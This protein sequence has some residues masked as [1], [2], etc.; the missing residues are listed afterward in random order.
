MGKIRVKTLG[1]E[2]FEAKQADKDKKRR[3]SKKAAKEK[4][5][6]KG[7]GL[8]GGQQVKVMEGVELKPE[9]EALLKDEAQP[10][11]KKAKVKKI[12]AKIRSRRYQ[13]LRGLVDRN[14]FYTLKDALKLLIKTATTKFDAAV[15]IH[16]N[17]NPAILDKNKLSLSG[18][19]T[20][21]HGTGK[22]RRIVI[23]DDTVLKNI[24]NNKL[25]FD[26]LVTNPQY[27]PKLAKFARVLGPKGLMPNPKNGTITKTPE[28]RAKELE[29]GEI[30]WKTEPDHPVIHQ[31]IGK[32]SFGEEKIKDNLTSFVKAV[33]SGKITKLTL[34][35][36]MGP[37]IKVDVS[38]I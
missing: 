31:S 16:I 14:K 38:T 3:E 12:R 15:D 10:E 9:I 21:P 34:C 1:D 5:H 13:T 7:V 23:V 6:V 2:A 17:I 18:T 37:G 28:K 29:G 30:A 27:M 25:D 26:V 22:K 36:S 33:N 32:I 24:E 19:V 11:E 8:K 20:L 35:S 4:A